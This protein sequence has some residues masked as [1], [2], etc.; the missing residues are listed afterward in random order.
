MSHRF[1]RCKRRR[2]KALPGSALLTLG[3]GIGGGGQ[4]N[5]PSSPWPASCSP[6]ILNDLHVA[7]WGCH[8]RRTNTAGALR[9]NYH[10]YTQ[11][12]RREATEFVNVEGPPKTRC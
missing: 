5:S 9:Q 6:C 10:N 3:T 2:R 8:T 12:E 4:R 11:N 1:L 7:A